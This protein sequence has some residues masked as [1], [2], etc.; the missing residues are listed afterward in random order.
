MRPWIAVSLGFTRVC[1][2]IVVIEIERA[3]ISSSSCALL[4]CTPLSH[5]RVWG[6]AKLFIDTFDLIAQVNGTRW[7][8]GWA[9]RW[10]RA[11]SQGEITSSSNDAYARARDSP[12]NCFLIQKYF[13]IITCLIIWKNLECCF[14]FLSRRKARRK[15][16]GIFLNCFQFLLRERALLHD[17]RSNW[18]MRGVWCCCCFQ[19]ILLLFSNPTHPRKEQ[20]LTWYAKETLSSF[21]F[22]SL[23]SF[24]RIVHDPSAFDHSA[25]AA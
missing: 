15:M 12:E 21:H 3:Y 1:L 6:V 19:Q 16:L 8:V 4:C 22:L 11:H 14:L 24:S 17:D 5:E 23:L 7:S 9:S 25:A 13:S 2:S 20:Q 10:S 18:N